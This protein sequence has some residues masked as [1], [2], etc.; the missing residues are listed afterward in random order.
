MI[1]LFLA[2]MIGTGTL[3]D[4]YRAKWQFDPDGLGRVTK[5][6]SIRSARGGVGVLLLDATAEYLTLVRA[7]SA[8]TSLATPSNIDNALNNGQANAAKT[9]FE[10][11]GIPGE[12]INQG[13][14]RREVIRAVV[15]LFLFSQRLEGRFGTGF[16]E[17]AQQRGVTF[18]TQYADFPQALKDE[19]VAVRD[20][21]GWDNL[22]LTNQS[23]LRQIMKRVSEQFELTPIFIAGEEI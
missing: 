13:D 14:T 12:F 19:F 7:D 5:A 17:K 16:W 9:I 1:E 6:G 21:H 8:M 20:E 3:P 11:V 22:G 4:P 2:P 10:G 15:G 18:D 23:T